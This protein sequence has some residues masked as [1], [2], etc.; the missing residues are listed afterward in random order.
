MLLEFL[1]S[2][3]ID[4]SFFYVYFGIIII[5]LGA[6]VLMNIQWNKS[7]TTHAFF[8]K[9]HQMLKVNPSQ[10]NKPIMTRESFIDWLTLIQSRTSEK[11]DKEDNTSSYFTSDFKIRGGQL[12]KAAA[13]SPFLKNIVFSSSFY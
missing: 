9:N 8:I 6:L 3:L 11:D 10:I 5:S 4:S 2:A 13:C 12:C 1:N 7:M